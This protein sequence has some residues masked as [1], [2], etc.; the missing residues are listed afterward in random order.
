[1]TK[2]RLCELTRLRQSRRRHWAGS[3]RGGIDV[4][5]PARHAMGWPTSSIRW[6]R[7]FMQAR[8]ND[9]GWRADILR[10]STRTIRRGG[11]PEIPRTYVFGGLRLEI[12]RRSINTTM[13]GRPN[14]R[15]ITSRAQC[16]GTE[17]EWMIGAEIRKANM[18]GRRRVHKASRRGRT[19]VALFTRAGGPAACALPRDGALASAKSDRRTSRTRSD[20]MVMGT[21]SR[22]GGEISEVTGQAAGR[23]ND[24]RMTLRRRHSTHCATNR[25]P[26]SCRSR[27]S[28]AARGMLDANLNRSD[29]RPRC[30]S[31]YT[32][33]RSTSPEGIEN[34]RLVL[35]RRMCSIISEESRGR[36][37][38]E[39]IERVTAERR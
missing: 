19:D 16:Q 18:P 37:Y 15:A 7:I 28:V 31:R 25:T 33:R 9:A 2:E 3:D 8:R 13:F 30:S 5:P 11:A 21:I 29:I 32:V 10:N 34:R 39:A 6:G 38:D 22:R 23:R 35:A 20:G 4:L 17:L 36:A 26:I 1:M 24:P 14:L 27:R 12:A